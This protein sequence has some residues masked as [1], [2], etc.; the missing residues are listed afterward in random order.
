MD[1]CALEPL[2]KMERAMPIKRQHVPLFPS[3]LTMEITSLN[4]SWAAPFGLCVDGHVRNSQPQTI[5]IITVIECKITIKRATSFPFIKRRLRVFCVGGNN[6][7]FHTSQLVPLGIV[8]KFCGTLLRL[9]VIPCLVWVWVGV[10][11]TRMP[12]WYFSTAGASPTPPSSFQ[13]EVT[14]P[15]ARACMLAIILI[16]L[17]GA[18]TRTARHRRAGVG[19]HWRTGAEMSK[20]WIMN[21]K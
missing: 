10:G 17:G 5:I 14:W 18:W 9:F 7:P 21:N 15:E 2:R 12:V 4:C 19:A 16:I 20:R 3:E 13:R 1:P 11:W 8:R 6:I